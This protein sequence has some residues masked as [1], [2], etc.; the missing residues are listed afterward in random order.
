MEKLNMVS[1]EHKGIKELA[2][3]IEFL[4]EELAILKERI[5]ELERERED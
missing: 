2:D 5:A 1:V 4:F 3:E